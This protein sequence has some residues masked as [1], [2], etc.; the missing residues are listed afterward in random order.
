MIKINDGAEVFMSFADELRNEPNRYKQE[1]EARI[2][3][4]WNTLVMKLHSIMKDICREAARQG[5]REQYLDIFNLIEAFYEEEYVYKDYHFEDGEQVY[6]L[7]FDDSN[8][9]QFWEKMRGYFYHYTVGRQTE[10]E[11]FPNLFGLFQSDAEIVKDGLGSMLKKDG[12]QVEV[13]MRKI[14]KIYREEEI[15]VEYTSFEKILTGKSGYM[16][17]KRVEDTTL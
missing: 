17:T 3:H 2:I 7:S 16:K 8:E 1:Q 4:D 9:G 10:R 14:S 6:E 5:R 11:P 13:N 12:L 15:N